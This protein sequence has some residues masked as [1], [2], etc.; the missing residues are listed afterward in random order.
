VRSAILHLLPRLL[1][2]ASRH[3]AAYAELLTEEAAALGKVVAK[4]IIALAIALVGALLT[5]VLGCAWIIMEFWDTR[6]RELS[7]VALIVTFA[8]CTT[9]A[10]VIALRNPSPDKTAFGRIRAEWDADQIMIN[11]MFNSA[12]PEAETEA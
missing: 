11:E 10:L 5:L 2:I 3:L 4:R 9:T 7:V 8:L 1:P 6:W 12:P